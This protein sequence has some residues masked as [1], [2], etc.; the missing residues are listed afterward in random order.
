[1]EFTALD[2]LLPLPEL[3]LKGHFS[4]QQLMGI[5]IASRD[6]SA[7]SGSA[8]LDFLKTSLSFRGGFIYRLDL[9]G[10]SVD[11]RVGQPGAK[12]ARPDGLFVLCNLLIPCW[13]G[14]TPVTLMPVDGSKAFRRSQLDVSC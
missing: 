2:M 9:G 13:G 10:K 6:G 11:G 4:D 7:W 8:G 14:K 3:I 1:M 5:N 12:E